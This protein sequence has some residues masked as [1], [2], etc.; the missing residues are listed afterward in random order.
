[1]NNHQSDDTPLG[2]IEKL[3]FDTALMLVLIL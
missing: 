3:H 2:S 1:M